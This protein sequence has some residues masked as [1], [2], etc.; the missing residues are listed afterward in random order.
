MHPLPVQRVTALQAGKRRAGTVQVMLDE[1]P[2]PL[3]RESRC[4][5][6]AIRVGTAW[7]PDLAAAVAHTNRVD[8]VR[9]RA[10]RRLK[11]RPRSRAEL[12]AALREHEPDSA[13][14]DLALGELARAGLIDDVA[15]AHMLVDQQTSKGAG[16][17]YLA[18]QQLAAKGVDVRVIADAI[19]PHATDPFEDAC[20][21]IRERCARTSRAEPAARTAARML[22]LLASR[23][24]E[25][26]IALDAI[27]ACF[28]DALDLDAHFDTHEES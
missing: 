23:G 8:A 9:D 22:R 25:E 5:E 21:L 4:V 20:A 15:F 6:L 26:H 11:T 2:G 13:I 12:V 18:E 17:L 10:L 19:K 27:Q 7:T 1:K 24:F 28:G 14:I 3:V 16:R